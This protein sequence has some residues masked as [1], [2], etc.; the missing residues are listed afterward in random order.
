MLAAFFDRRGRECQPLTWRMRGVCL[1]MHSCFLF[2]C[3]RK[4]GHAAGR[5]SLAPGAKRANLRESRW[6]RKSLV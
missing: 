1:F 6:G 2:L 3:Q 4:Q 5:K